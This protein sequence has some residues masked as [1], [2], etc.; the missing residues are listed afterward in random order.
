MDITTL[1]KSELIELLYAV[2]EKAKKKSG[3]DDDLSTYFTN[4]TS[5]KPFKMERGGPDKRSRNLSRK[6]GAKT[7]RILFEDESHDRIAREA[8]VRRRRGIPTMTGV[9]GKELLD[10]VTEK[11]KKKGRGGGD[12]GPKATGN[13]P[14]PSKTFTREAMNRPEGPGNKYSAP[15]GP[16]KKGKSM[17]KSWQWESPMGKMRGKELFESTEKA[18]KKGVQSP[19]DVGYA[20]YPVRDGVTKYYVGGGKTAAGSDW[21]QKKPSAGQTTPRVM[22]GSRVD[23]NKQNR[24]AAAN[25]KKAT[26]NKRSDFHKM[27]VNEAQMKRRKELQTEQAIDQYLSYESEMDDNRQLMFEVIT[28]KAHKPGHK[29]PQDFKK[30]NDVKPGGRWSPPDEKPRFAGFDNSVPDA[31]RIPRLKKE[32]Q[33]SDKRI[34]QEGGFRMRNVGY[35]HLRNPIIKDRYAAG[36]R[37]E[38]PYSPENVGDQR[39]NAKVRQEAA[40]TR[41]QVAVGRAGQKRKKGLPAIVP[42]RRN[43]ELFEATEKAMK[44]S[45]PPPPRRANA[46]DSAMANQSSAEFNKRQAQ[47]EQSRRN[48]VRQGVERQ[49][50]GD[51]ERNRTGRYKADLVMYDDEG[52]KSPAVRLERYTNPVNQRKWLSGSRL[53]EKHRPKASKV[54]KM[55]GAEVYRASQVDTDAKRRRKELDD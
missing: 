46:Q 41:M 38:R 10:A 26:L 32:E 16:D 14:R 9:R 21:P 31:K 24:D 3:K 18:K 19:D 8:D 6:S 54:S 27:K 4:R 34:R 13:E 30:E 50:H 45:A 1:S 48:R 17:K 5:Y 42:T 55:S 15:Q 20:Q 22:P 52:K 12:G 7:P 47:T 23:I 43:K 40:K 25:Q 2:T 51:E 35:D 29:S 49:S 11:G 37:Q 39:R 36:S 44:K 33:E 28:E 53:I